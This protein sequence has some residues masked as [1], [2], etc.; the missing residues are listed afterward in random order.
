MSRGGDESL[1]S[2]ITKTH[3]YFNQKYFALS[4]EE[5]YYIPLSG[6]R[7]SK[8]KK[9]RDVAKSEVFIRRITRFSI[10]LIFRSDI[11]RNCY[12][13]LLSSSC[14]FLSFLNQIDIMPSLAPLRVHV[15]WKFV[16][17]PYAITIFFFMPQP[18]PRLAI[19][20]YSF[21]IK[22]QRDENIRQTRVARAQSSLLSFYLA[23][24]MLVLINNFF[25]K[26]RVA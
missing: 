11:A 3:E 12:K 17:F 9:Q 10:A 8:E 7:R 23:D 5:S 16:P 14:V 6:S 20:S 13:K 4:S 18:K 25:S 24:F 2:Q 21:L 1:G 26:E 19:F 15:V 22:I